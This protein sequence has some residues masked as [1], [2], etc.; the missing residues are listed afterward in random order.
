MHDEF[1]Q[2][3]LNRGNNWGKQPVPITKEEEDFSNLGR[4]VQ[5]S[6]KK[7]IIEKYDKSWGIFSGKVRDHANKARS[8][9][10]VMRSLNKMATPRDE[11]ITKD[12]KY[13]NDSQLKYLLADYGTQ[14]EE[15]RTAYLEGQAKLKEFT[16]LD[17]D[18]KNKILKKQWFPDNFLENDFTV[19]VKPTSS[20]GRIKRKTRR[21]MKK[22]SK[23]TRKA[24]KK[25]TT[26]KRIRKNKSMKSRTNRK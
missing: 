18:G 6:I 5:K 22:S 17:N 21:S 25:R 16:G 14:D 12:K 26:R 4:E 2:M 1:A 15:I 7:T 23:K 13:I 19:K 20:G 9:D 24:K 3:G 8:G 10:F 11:K